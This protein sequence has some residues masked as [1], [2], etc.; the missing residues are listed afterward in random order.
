MKKIFTY[1]FIGILCFAL[2]DCNSYLD[3]AKHGN[4]G[5]MEDFYET[6]EDAEQAAAALY[7]GVDNVFFYWYM[8]KNMLADDFW[9]GGGTR[10]DRP[11]YE[12]LNEYHFDTDQETI[13]Y[14]YSNL[15][16]LVY[17]ANLILDN[18][19]PDSAVKQRVYAEAKFMRAWAHFELV[20]LWGTAPI[21][22]HLLKSDEYR[23]GNGT[24]E[25]TWEFIENELNEAI[26]SGWLP[27]KNGVND[28]ETTIRVTKELAEA[29]LGKSYL[30]QGK[31]SDA[32]TML[33]KVINS[34]LYAL[35][36]GDYGLIL[37]TASNNCCE[38]MFEVQKRND[39]DKAWWQWGWTW[40][41]MGWRTA[42]FDISEP[43][44]SEIAMG[45]YGFGCPQSSLYDAFV[46][47]EG[48]DGYRL[49][50]VIYTMD[51]MEAYGM[52]LTPGMYLMGCEGYMCWKTRSTM[53]DVVTDNSSMQVLQWI[54]SPIMRYAEVLL[55]AAEAQYMTGNTSKATEYVN[56]I[57][58]RA[59]AAT[60]S[61]VTL[62]D[63]KVEKRLELCYESVR[64]Q[65]L[66]RWGDAA[67]VLGEQGK[68]VPSYSTA[69]VDWQFHNTE[70]GF[71]TK[72]NLLPIPRQEIELNP[73]MTQNEGW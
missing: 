50:N 68:D 3:I 19:E 63:I 30:F 72:H 55:L 14:T 36:D 4:M 11:E 70:Y 24:P 69:G 33:D 22:D 62:D 42:Y 58:T 65:D 9:C 46:A 66:V 12:E 26:D 57:R 51:Q 32:A 31:Y 61:S 59:K 38:S 67:S 39:T 60:K 45:T 48:V 52:S 17:Y 25:A 73:N 18:L 8:L 47:E 64:W 5:S 41:Y 34:G 28:E 10:G 21:V 40:A 29:L 56:Q 16:T 7:L 37:Q 23:Q 43:A 6:D 2:V 35:W 71:K 1:L 27:S 20:T 53:D 44:Q 15:Y 54:N 13:N 49:N